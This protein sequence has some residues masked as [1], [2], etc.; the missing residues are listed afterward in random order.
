MAKSKLNN[1]LKFDDFS[2]ELP[3]NKQKK[4]KRTD[5]GVDVLNEKVWI[6]PT[7]LNPVIELAREDDDIAKLAKFCLAL[8]NKSV[9]SDQY[10]ADKY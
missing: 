3:T 6:K 9:D 4:T 2:G 10:H 1:L 5:V 7:I 8:A